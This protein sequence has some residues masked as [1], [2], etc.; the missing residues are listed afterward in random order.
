M[1]CHRNLDIHSIARNRWCRRLAW[2]L[3]GLLGM[4]SH[5]HAQHHLP[6][7]SSDLVLEA[8]SISVSTLLFAQSRWN[9][10]G[11]L[12]VTDYRFRVEQVLLD[13]GIGG[14]E[15]VVSQGGG[16]V[17]SES[18][19]LSSN[20]RLQVGERYVVFLDPDRGEMFAPFVGG[21]QG[22]YRI[23]A[24]GVAVALSGKDR[25]LLGDLVGE[26][27][28]L[29]AVRGND[30]PLRVHGP[31][32]QGARALPSK[33]WSPAAPRGPVPSADSREPSAGDAVDIGMPIAGEPLAPAV[34]DPREH[35]QLQAALPGAPAWH[36]ARRASRPIVWDQW[37]E[38]WWVGFVDQSMM[39]KWNRVVDNL[40][41][42]SN[43]QLG[44]WAWRN[45]RFEMVGFPSNA[46]MVAQFGEGWGTNTL[47][48]TWR[49]WDTGSTVIRE[50]DIAFNPAYC[51]TLDEFVSATQ[52]DTCW[53]VRQTALHELGHG[54]GLDHPW[55]FENVWFDSVM[56][57]APKQF[58]LPMLHEDDTDAARIAYPGTPSINVN[59][60]ISMYTTGDNASSMQATY[61][62][63]FPSSIS[64][65]HGGSLT[66]GS[67]NI[68]N[69]GR[70][71]FSSPQVEIYL[72]HEW[73]NWDAPYVFLRTA[74]FGTTLAPSTTVVHTLSPTTIPA[75]VPVG[76]YYPSLYLR[77]AGDEDGESNTAASSPGVRLTVNNIP[78]TLAPT[79]AWR[80]WSLGRVGPSGIWRLNLPVVAGRSY[81]L[82]LCP[83][84]GGGS[85]TFDTVLSVV[86]VTS[87]DDYCGLQS[88]VQFT[89]TST[90]TRTVEIRGYNGAQG[91]FTLAYRQLVTDRIFANGFEGN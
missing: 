52:N 7:S 15:F 44:T 40:N 57:Y 74:S 58:R 8:E 18:Q 36:V 66:F 49:R 59:G 30:P 68:E 34:D 80:T 65:T 70:T 31:A 62:A 91:T 26:I 35:G 12:I 14:F 47:A 76:L 46:D 61:T 22:I 6:M 5:A 51:W 19:D 78:A 17:G 33:T 71:T 21:D 89:S 20:P 10:K 28:S 73:R 88:R 4:A 75:T 29:L 42:V 16:S 43:S 39:I 45:D 37:P 11:N 50:A 3:A 90:T 13:G 32:A 9:A 55:E 48:V 77:L 79:E 38:D 24:A 72:S 83:A 63:A 64:V 81:E 67:V 53:G 84:L 25:M 85:A 69:P 23:D 56:N 41:R 86:G 82:S 60:L 1:N 27:R 54:W 87:N 2:C